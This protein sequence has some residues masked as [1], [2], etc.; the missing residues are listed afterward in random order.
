MINLGN[1]YRRYALTVDKINEYASTDP[2]LFVDKSEQAYRADIREIAWRIFSSP[3][4]VKVVMLA[5]PSASGK[6]TTAKMLGE[7]LEGMGSAAQII[8]M[9]NFYLGEARVPKTPEGQPDFEC[10]EALN[11]P[12]LERCIGELLKTGECDIPMFDFAK[13]SLPD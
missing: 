7:E 9:D 1:S 5:G 11:I 6:T 4:P 2:A 10:V 12:E 8:S 3:E 13:A